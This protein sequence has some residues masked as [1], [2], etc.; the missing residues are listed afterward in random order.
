MILPMILRHPLCQSL[1]LVPILEF[2]NGEGEAV[3]VAFTDAEHLELVVMVGFPSY[4]TTG[5]QAVN[6]QSFILIVPLGMVF[7]AVFS[8]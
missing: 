3:V 4:N 8:F 1:C 2:L 7:R 6:T 5:N